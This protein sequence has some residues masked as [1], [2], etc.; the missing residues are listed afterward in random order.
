MKI[1]EDDGVCYTDE[2]VE[3][4]ELVMTMTMD[5]LEGVIYF[6]FCEVASVWK[7]GIPTHEEYHDE[8][9]CKSV[10]G[11]TMET[12]VRKRVKMTDKYLLE[13]ERETRYYNIWEKLNYNEK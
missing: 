8:M 2:F 12:T 11:E 5:E 6:R 10:E 13:R 9:A 3:N 4:H 7:D 1:K